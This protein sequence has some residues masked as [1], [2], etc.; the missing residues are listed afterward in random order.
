MAL[1][2]YYAYS[3]SAVDLASQVSFLQ[4]TT[5]AGSLSSNGTNPTQFT[6]GLSGTVSLITEI[7]T[8]ATSW[9]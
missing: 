7:K 2:Q 1:E 9:A 5:D 8:A 6:P 4:W 3:L